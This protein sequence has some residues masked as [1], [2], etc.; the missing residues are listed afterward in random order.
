MTSYSRPDELA[1]ESEIKRAKTRTS[2]ARQV[3]ETAASF[4]T[5]GLAAKSAS[6]ILPFLSQYVPEELAY[7][8]INKVM[9]GLG[10]FLKKGTAQGLSLKSGLEFLK[11]EFGSSK[12]AE[13]AKQNKN[14]I[15]QESPELFQ[16]MTEE[17]KKGRKPIEA[18]ALAQSD[19]RFSE[20]IKKLMKSHK[21]PWSKI[22][23]SLFGT[24]E[25]AQQQQSQQLQQNALAEEVMNPPGSQPTQAPTAEAQAFVKPQQGGQ[26]KNIRE[27]LAKQQGQV[28]PQPQQQSAG[29]SALLAAL[30]KILKM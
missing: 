29:D 2:E 17:I 9:P 30:D 19:K 5:A 26:P 21:T 23:E 25:T 3:L 14:I 18:G 20:V 8:G 10:D 27:L 22:I 12:K 13:P 4:G 15:E 16:F 1:A 7:K 6:K 24:G 11:N 28:S